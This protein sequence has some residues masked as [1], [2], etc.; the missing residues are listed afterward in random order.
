MGQARFRAVMM[1][2]AVWGAML[3]A[4]AQTTSLSISTTTLPAGASGAAYSVT[5]TAVGGTPPYRWHVDSGRP[6]RG[7]HLLA[8]GRVSARLDV[9]R[10]SSF[11]LAVTAGSAW[12][13]FPPA[14]VTRVIVPFIR[15][16]GALPNG[17]TS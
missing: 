16:L 10:H 14:F 4:A 11:T 17:A 6:P 1:A 8:N 12:L 7:F 5:L 13:L 15:V 9:G 3:P 2:V